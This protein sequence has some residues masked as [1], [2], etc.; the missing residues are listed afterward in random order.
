[1]RLGHIKKYVIGT[2][3]G[4][5]VLSAGIAVS[6]AYA[7]EKL[8]DRI[9]DNI[10]IGE[11]AVG[12]MSEDEAKQAVEEYVSSV[13]DTPI[14]LNVSSKSVKASAGQLGVEWE[15][16]GVLDEALAIGKSGS[17]ITRYKDKKDLEHEPKELPLV[18]GTDESKIKSYLKKNEKKF[19][20]EAVDGGLTRENGAFKITGGDEGIAVNIPESVKVI[21]DYIS[22]DWDK[23]EAEI[24]LDADVVKP[25]GSKEELSKVKD[26]LGKF[27][28]NYSSSS[29][30]R[31]MNVSNGCERINGA[32]LY[33]GDEFS[34]YEAVSPFD[35]EHGYALAG[36]YENGTVVET[37]GG[38]ICQVSTTLYNAVIRAELEITERFAHSMIVNYVEPSMDAA[39]AGTYKDLKFKN[40]TE[41]P[42][43][44]EGITSG[45]IIS[46]NIYG[47][48]TRD[49][50]REVIF[51]SEIISVNSPKTQIQGS[52]SHNVGYVSVQQSAHVGKVAKLWKIVKM[53]G[54]EQSREEFNNS[55]YSASPKIILVGTNTASDEAR[56]YIQNA[57]ASQNEAGIYAAAAQA[58]NI[59]ARP[60][61]PEQPEEDPAE[62]D[63][64]P[65]DEK[66]NNDNKDNQDGK[67][68]KDNKGNKDN[69]DD[70]N[71]KGDANKE[72]NADKDNTDNKD[73]PQTGTI[74]G[75]S[76]SSKKDNANVS[77]EA[78]DKGSLVE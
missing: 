5:A 61:Q 57:I 15:N 43:Y 71:N 3:A 66:D 70:K 73:K 69:K 39:I 54:V 10:Y 14:T 59:A 18:F 11:V 25:R 21:A 27:S 77:S 13:Q 17:L 29:A 78:S 42:I 6:Q 48:E 76:G 40:N 62:T 52:A 58:A 1:M 46:F 12:G 47:Q 51:E 9:L 23:Q 55:N 56:A 32:L 2:I 8:S 65:D 72:D 20:Q 63:E 37:Y 30:G 44:I 4:V 53:N 64:K 22:N 49:P 36:S 50:Q 74:S 34:V 19:N 60:Q 45:G 7:D 16:V 68:D 26:V 75:D 33:P 41:A 28:T 31:A 38:G 35:A 24:E 67:G